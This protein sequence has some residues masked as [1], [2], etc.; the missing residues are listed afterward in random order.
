MDDLLKRACLAFVGFSFGIFG[1]SM[2]MVS[3]GSAVASNPA[4]HF[5][6]FCR[7]LFLWLWMLLIGGVALGFLLIISFCIFEQ[8]TIFL[9]EDKEAKWR[10]RIR[11]ANPSEPSYRKELEVKQ[12]IENHEA[13][14]RKQK[15]EEQERIELEE[16]RRKMRSAKAAV[17]DAL[18][19][20]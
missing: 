13:Q 19:D 6:S 11:N 1:I 9:R 10:E 16:L 15:E 18:D 8:I 12:R 4:W 2:A 3:N 20:F 5:V 14:V 17:D 7:N